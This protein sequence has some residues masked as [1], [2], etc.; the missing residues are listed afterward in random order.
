[1]NL[2][3]GSVGLELSYSVG[4]KKCSAHRNEFILPEGNLL[5][6]P[7]SCVLQENTTSC[8]REIQS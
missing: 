7:L 1:M 6:P 8:N 5:L 3:V 2:A 4:Y